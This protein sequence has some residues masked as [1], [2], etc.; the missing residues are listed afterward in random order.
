MGGCSG[1]AG[2]LSQVEGEAWTKPPLYDRNHLLLTWTGVKSASVSILSHLH[3]HCC[4]HGS[5][6]FWGTWSCFCQHWVTALI[7]TLTPAQ[8]FLEVQCT[9]SNRVR[10]C[11]S[12][13]GLLASENVIPPVESWG[14]QGYWLLRLHAPPLTHQSLKLQEPRIQLHLTR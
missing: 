5:L 12:A 2:V 10:R 4:N 9:S 11:P 3:W 7:N 14:G 13:T 8:H 6:C 1:E